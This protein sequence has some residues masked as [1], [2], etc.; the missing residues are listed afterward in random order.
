MNNKYKKISAVFV[1]FVL[2]L[3]LVFT[4][5]SCN[6]AK[7]R[8]YKVNE[9]YRLTC[10]EGSRSYLTVD[11]PIS[12]GCQSVD[13]LTVNDADEYRF[14]EKDGFQVLH[15]E[16]IG[17]G[18]ERTV[19]VSY[20]VKLLSGD[21]IWDMDNRDEYLKPN[22]NVDSD[23][24]NIIDAALSLKVE[25]DDY[26]T[27][28]QISAYVSKTVRSDTATKVNAKTL[29]ASKILEQKKG[30]CNDYA[31]L[32]AAMLRAAGIPARPVS[33]LV[34][35]NLKEAGD[36]S[37]SA[38]GGSHAWVEFYADGKWHFADPTWGN[39]YFDNPDGYH[40]SYGTELVDISTDEYQAQFDD[41]MKI[42]ESEGY[43]VIASMTAPIKFTVWSDDPET[44][45]VPKVNAAEIKVRD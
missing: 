39:G 10:A 17:D 21:Q 7:D 8:S 40:I 37:H 44:V 27:A 18:N 13:G 35:N 38:N 14:E 34:F 24:K 22:E 6:T 28:K 23:N 16:I 45:V 5:T 11:L 31:N 25:N 2:L 12:Y 42:M 9:T 33:G 19:D 1:D 20:T 4:L 30:V 29:P 3:A 26:L 43:K 32:A 41:Q 15:A 36:W